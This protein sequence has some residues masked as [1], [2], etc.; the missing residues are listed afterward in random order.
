MGRMNGHCSQSPTATDPLPDYPRKTFIAE[1]ADGFRLVFEH[2]ES[3][4]DQGASIVLCPGFGGNRFNFDL[5]EKHSLAR[6]LASEGFDTWIVELR[7][8]GRSKAAV[9]SAEA[10]RSWNMDDHIEKDLPALLD[11][12]ARVSAGPGVIWIG[13]SLGGMVVYGLLARYP[14]HERFFTGL[15]TIGSPGYVEPLRWKHAASAATFFLRLMR[16]WPTIPVRSILQ[17]LFSDLGRQVGL[18]RVRRRWLHPENMNQSVL[19]DTAR[20]GLEDFSVGTLRQW[21]T[22]MPRGGLL[23]SKGDYNYFHNLGQIKLPILLI[24]G[25]KDG[26]TS[27]PTIMAVFDKVGSKDKTIRVF[28]EAG[29]EIGPDSVAKSRR[30]G[31]DYG[32]AD[33]L[34]GEATRSEV[35]PFIARWIREHARTGEDH[36]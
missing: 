20:R 26:I 18:T 11:A 12:V 7:G 2:V 25:T 13:H 15:I 27:V 6:Y 30:D 1:A 23:N 32:H 17:I 19:S 14:H 10:R 24:G 22:S 34:L 16:G 35:F 8:A 21:L 29:F 36:R 9:S 3:R 5:D 33:L 31:T 28:G 4:T